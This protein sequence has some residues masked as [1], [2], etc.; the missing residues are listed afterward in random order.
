MAFFPDVEGLCGAALPSKRF[1][2]VMFRRRSE[3][4]ECVTGGLWPPEGLRAKR[5]T[6]KRWIKQK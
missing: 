1:V 5:F 6:D 3:D 4:N 2:L